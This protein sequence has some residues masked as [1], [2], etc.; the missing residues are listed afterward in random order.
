VPRWLTEGFA[1][2]H[3]SDFSLARATTLTGAVIARRVVPLW[4]LEQAFPARE[5]AAALAYAESYDFVAFLAQHG[6]WPF[7]NFLA[8]LAHGS[9]PDGAARAAFGR[10]LVDL[11]DEWLESLRTRYLFFPFGLGGAA[12]W[13]SGGLLL[14]AG[15]WRRRR[16]AR[17]TLARWE[18]E[19]EQELE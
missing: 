7:H 14:V 9:S 10:R 15:W 13:A 6:R 4:R 11:E 16:Q 8:E 2:L 5:D 12:L 17:A 3:S 18:R 1:Y 19:E